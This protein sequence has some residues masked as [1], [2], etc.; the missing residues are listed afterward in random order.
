MYFNNY[1][2]NYNFAKTFEVGDQLAPV[3]AWWYFSHKFSF[4]GNN[5]GDWDF[6]FIKNVS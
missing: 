1:F 5:F 4:T 6:T 2:T 3:I